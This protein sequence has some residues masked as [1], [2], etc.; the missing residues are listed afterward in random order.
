MHYAIVYC[1]TSVTG[2]ECWVEA[3]AAVTVTVKAFW[4]VGV[5]ILTL[6]DPDLVE[7]AEDVAVTVTVAGFGTG[8]GGAV[9]SPVL[10]TVPLAAP[11]VTAQVTAVFDVPVTFAVNC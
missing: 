6:P 10:S 3:S 5:W 1:T 9:Y 4:V 2:C 8:N 7:S 11:P